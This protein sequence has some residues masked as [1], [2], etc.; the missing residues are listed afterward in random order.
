MIVADDDAARV[1]YFPKFGLHQAARPLLK[2]QCA[3]D[4][5][6][7]L[8]FHSNEFEDL[9]FCVL[10][11]QSINIPDLGEKAR[12]IKRLFL[13]GVGTISGIEQFENVEDIRLDN[14]PKN[15]IDFKAFRKLRHL[16]TDEWKKTFE[17]AIFSLSELRSLG[18]NGFSGEYCG[19]YRSLPNLRYAGFDRGRLK[20]LDGLAACAELESI[21]LGDLRNFTDLGDLRSF[22]NISSLSLHSLPKLDW[23]MTLSGATTLQTLSLASLKSLR[24]ILQLDGLTDLEDIRVTDCP[25]VEVNLSAIRD[26]GNLRKLLL[27][28]PHVSLS[29]DDLFSQRNLEFFSV[30]ISDELLSAQD[31]DLFEL[32]KRNDR[33]ISSVQRVG[34]KKSRFIQVF[35]TVADRT[36]Y[37]FTHFSAAPRPATLVP[38]E[39]GATKLNQE[40]TSTTMA[41][42]LLPDAALNK[43]VWSFTG[44]R[45]DDASEF[46]E[47]VREYQIDILGTD[48]W[49][50]DEIILPVPQVLISYP[51]DNAD[52]DVETI[53]LTSANKDAFT[54]LDLLYQIHNAIVESVEHSD[55]HFNEGL[56]LNSAPPPEL[57]DALYILNLGS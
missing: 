19:L 52:G 11:H 32:A 55:H 21:V 23:D 51:V 4:N 42:Q 31:E 29:L 57:G 48:E 7:T 9:M 45:C 8:A 26:M 38:G 47:R 35:F 41:K 56:S 16:H 27:N 22:K 33:V 2:G 15:G 10:P 40:V 6:S 34:P 13:S 50:P 1:A 28:V 37:S 18:I 20:S 54:A 14:F 36:A 30:S 39:H 53:R 5:T 3:W 46:S 49:A 17:G 44:G 12:T 25:N 43:V 24:G